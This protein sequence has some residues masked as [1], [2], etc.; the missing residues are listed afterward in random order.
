MDPGEGLTDAGQFRN[1]GET[2]PSPLRHAGFSAFGA[3]GPAFFS[4][5]RGKSARGAARDDDR[6]GRKDKEKIRYPSARHAISGSPGRFVRGPDPDP[7]P[8][9]ARGREGERDGEGSCKPP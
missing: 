3:A 2:F 6:C 9:V 7:A 8:S 5:R 4:S 1:R